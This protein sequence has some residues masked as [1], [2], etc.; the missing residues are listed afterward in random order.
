MSKTEV[1]AEQSV[2]K[3]IEDTEFRYEIAPELETLVKEV[4]EKRDEID[5]TAQSHGLEPGSKR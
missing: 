5:H 1:K 3:L 4:L 2:E